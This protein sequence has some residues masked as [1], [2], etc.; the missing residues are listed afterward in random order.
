MTQ[1]ELFKKYGI[2]ESHNAWSITDS[3]YAI[4]I[5]RFMHNRLPNDNDTTLKYIIE[6]TDQMHAK[7]GGVLPRLIK[8]CD[9]NNLNW[10]SFYLT[11]KRMIYK[12]SN[13]IITE[14]NS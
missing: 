12:F 5:F 6:F 11:A 7:K 8:F 13:E 4:D 9:K 3:R 14:I 2:D 10:G 1:K